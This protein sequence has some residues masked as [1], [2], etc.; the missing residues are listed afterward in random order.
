MKICRVSSPDLELK[1]YPSVK[2]IKEEWDSRLPDNH[3]LKSINWEA[4][5]NSYLPE[6]RFWFV[7]IYELGNWIGQAAFQVVEIKSNSFN[8][9]GL[10]RTVKGLVLSLL[11]TSNTQVL[12]CGNLFRQNQI[13]FY[14]QNNTNEE[15]IF[16]VV[17]KLTH[18][19][20]GIANPAV[21]LIKDF[22][23]KSTVDF[24]I[25]S[26][27]FKPL[28]E[29]TTMTMKVLPEWSNL[30]DYFRSL[31]KKY[32]QRFQKVRM[33]GLDVTRLELQEKDLAKY[34]GQIGKLYTE[35]IDRQNFK[36]FSV[37]A[38][39][40]LE[41]KKS[42]KNNFEIIGYF[43]ENQLIAFSTFHFYET[44]EMEIHYIGFDQMINEDKMLYF[45]I[46]F[47]GLERA[48]S[49]GVSTLFLGRGGF[50]A[51]ASLGAELTK[52]Q[53]FI[54]KKP[55][56]FAF[57]FQLI[58]Q[59]YQKSE[60]KIRIERNPFKKGENPNKEPIKMAESFT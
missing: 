15:K 22:K 7:Q 44:D 37:Q 12:V 38:D 58:Y 35:L 60:G 34:S 6:F 52:N 33:A 28:F 23:I 59:N 9:S 5:E 53:H 55:G 31:T 16:S 13:G 3:S 39:Y 24:Q 42:L 18:W 2:E 21:S 32:A 27:G 20:K 40:F 11:K 1:I 8:F 25:K 29:D 46:L 54:W 10:D 4:L 19:R 56:I 36:P 49:K 47:D 51:K 57:L 30:E 26:S 17:K 48:I 43:S 50:D 14:F 45:N 41:M